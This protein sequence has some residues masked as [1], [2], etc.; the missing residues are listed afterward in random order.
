MAT[1]FKTHGVVV[2][3][4]KQWNTKVVWN[5][6]HKMVT[7]RRQPKKILFK[8]K[9]LNDMN[10]NL[11]GGWFLKD[12]ANTNVWIE[13]Q[14][15]RGRKPLGEMHFLDAGEARE[16]AKRL[17]AAGLIV[18]VS[19]WGDGGRSVEAC[20]DATVGDIG[21]LASLVDDYNEAGCVDARL[22]LR[23]IGSIGGKPLKSFFG[24]WDDGQPLWLTG[25]LLGYP[26][27]NTISI[28]RGAI[29]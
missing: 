18:K 5:D 3:P 6:G 25:L 16:A 4:G 7:Y 2:T 15:I 24:K 21:N 14:L 20:Q 19:N 23:E 9:M 13:R 11:C 10:Q 17:K 28:Y 8:S 26:V 22:M 27:E 29:S 12:M 1:A